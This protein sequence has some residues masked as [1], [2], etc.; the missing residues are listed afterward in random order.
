MQPPTATYEF[1]SQSRPNTSKNKDIPASVNIDSKIPGQ[2]SLQNNK[3][4]KLVNMP[5][6]QKEGLK[7]TKTL[8]KND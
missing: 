4:L 3:K 2:F 5:L 8:K 6:S 1:K 7:L